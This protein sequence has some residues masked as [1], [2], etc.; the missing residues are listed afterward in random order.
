MTHLPPLYHNNNNIG[1]FQTSV[2]KSSKRNQEM[3]AFSTANETE[4]S[5]S[6]E[7]VIWV[8]FICPVFTRTPGESYRRQI[9]VSVV[10]SLVIRVTSSRD[11][12][13]LCWPILQF[14]IT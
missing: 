12:H 7:R 3:E 11:I 13:P 9:Q 2:L 8:K 10:M 1:Y 5:R 14:P 4:G 6:A